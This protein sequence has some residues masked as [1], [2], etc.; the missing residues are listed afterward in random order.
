MK[1]YY[2]ILG[3]EKTASTEEIKTA[4]RKLSKKFHPDLNAG[5][6]FFTDRFKEI[7]EA[8]DTLTDE[9]KRDDYDKK[10]FSFLNRGFDREFLEGLKR[11]QEEKRKA[12]EQKRKE[13]EQLR[14]EQFLRETEEALAQEERARV[15]AEQKRRRSKVMLWA[16]TILPVLI[17]AGLYAA[18]IIPNV[19]TRAEQA[20]DTMA[21]VPLADT[22]MAEKKDTV[23]KNNVPLEKD[24]RV[25]SLNG[26]WT[27][28]V[29]QFQ[30]KEDRPIEFSC[31][32]TRSRFQVEY[33]DNDCKGKWELIKIDEEDFHFRENITEGQDSCTQ[34]G[35]IVL[36]PYKRR[37][38][39]YSYYWPNDKTLAA[40]G[41]ITRR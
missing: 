25:R 35:L 38:Y 28:L 26:R 33:P 9:V 22:A 31:S 18:R 21:V 24:R 17:L 32:Y 36:S 4:F 8:Y 20:A 7:Q 16:V 1:N 5:D 23:A 40:S 12:E 10:L 19:K 34:G 27:G 37:Q 6:S 2:H 29:Y 30:L 11:R 13:E 41:Y 3:V 14:E 15:A 39:H